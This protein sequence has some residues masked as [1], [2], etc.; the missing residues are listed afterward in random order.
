MKL[1]VVQDPEKEGKLRRLQESVE[2][3]PDDPSLRFQLVRNHPSNSLI[4]LLFI[5]K[6]W[7]MRFLSSSIY[8]LIL[9]CKS[10]DMNLAFSID[11]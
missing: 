1:V 10:L 11:T 3:H 5:F 6:N 4:N 2:A 7:L 8:Y 9:K